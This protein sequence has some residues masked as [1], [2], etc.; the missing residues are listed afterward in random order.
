MEVKMLNF[1][2]YFITLKNNYLS[3]IKFKNIYI[4]YIKVF[5]YIKH[6]KSLTYLILTF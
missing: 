4:Q 2:E 5:I 6:G 3:E 1:W